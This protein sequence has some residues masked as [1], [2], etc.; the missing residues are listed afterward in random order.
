M[1]AFW[2]KVSSDIHTNNFKI[3]DVSVT[4][5]EK[6]FAPTNSIINKMQSASEHR[7]ELAEIIFKCSITDVSQ[8]LASASDTAYHGKKFDIMNRLPPCFFTV[9]AK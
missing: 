9:F 7:P 1:I 3:W 5:V 8:S 6:P 4:E 2:K